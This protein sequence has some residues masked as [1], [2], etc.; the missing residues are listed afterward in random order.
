MR[1][2]EIAH[3]LPAVYQD[4]VPGSPVLRAIL[5]AM[6][7]LHAPDEAA[8]AGFSAY[9]DPRRAPDPFVRMLAH[10]L[11]LGPYLE[12]ERLVDR[13]VTISPA[14]LRDLVA[15]AARAARLRGTAETII[16]VLTAATGV[17]G[18]TIEENPSDTAGRP[19][20]FHIRVT[21]P[22]AASNQIELVNRLVAGERPAWVTY[23]LATRGA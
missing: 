3:L 7:A 17:S 2:E 22:P 4:A 10:W 18:F 16:E 6:E 21:V 12:D 23:E 8:I 11:A 15:I 5:G 19:Q 14:P 1:A 9:L 13:R 20:P